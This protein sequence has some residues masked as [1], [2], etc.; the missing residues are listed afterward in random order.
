[1]VSEQFPGKSHRKERCT[2]GFGGGHSLYLCCAY[3]AKV[4]HKL[5]ATEISQLTPAEVSTCVSLSLKNT[6]RSDQSNSLQGTSHALGQEWPHSKE[7]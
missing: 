2:Q 6:T 1:M 5:E 7:P 3:S 4:A